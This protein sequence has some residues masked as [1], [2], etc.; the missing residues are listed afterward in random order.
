MEKKVKRDDFYKQELA[1]KVSINSL[2]TG[3]ENMTKETKNNT[4]PEGIYDF[5]TYSQKFLVYTNISDINEVY[6]ITPEIGKIPEGENVQ[7]I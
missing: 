1:I 6:K 7:N 3:G 4:H 2:L 5:S